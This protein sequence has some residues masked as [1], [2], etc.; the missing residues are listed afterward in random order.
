MCVDIFG[1][2]GP[3]VNYT[4]TYYGGYNIG[5]SRI[6]M[7]NGSPRTP[8]IAAHTAQLD[9]PVARAVC[10]QHDQPRHHAHLHP[11]HRPL[12]RACIATCRDR[13]SANMLPPSPSDPPGLVAA[14]QEVSSFIDVWLHTA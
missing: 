10:A 5:G 3:N 6:V 14:R 11:G 9:R 12:V 7:P 2:Q 8:R 13:R 1:L 4:N